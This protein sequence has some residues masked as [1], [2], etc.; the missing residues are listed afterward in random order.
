MYSSDEKTDMILIYGECLKN[1]SRAA[2][3][4]AERFPNRRAPT[5]TIFK[6]LENQLREK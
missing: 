3:L 4:Y 2:L 6:R 1:A 5:D